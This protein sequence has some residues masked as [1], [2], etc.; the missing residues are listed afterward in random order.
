MLDPK[1]LIH[2]MIILGVPCAIANRSNAQSPPATEDRRAI[3]GMMRNRRPAFLVRAEVNHATRNYR[4]GDAFSVRVAS[5][6]DSFVYVLYQQADGKVFQ[7]F[8][9]AHQPNNRLKARQPVDIPAQD[10]L[11]RWT[12]GPP[13]GKEIVKVIAARK[14]LQGLSNPAL[15]QKLFNAVSAKELKDVDLE[16][17]QEEPDEWT[18]HC[19]DVHT[20]AAAQAPI[21]AGS[22]R[23]GVFFGVSEYTF[24]AE[25]ERASGGKATMNLSSPHRDAR[26]L[27]ELLRETG[28]LAESRVYT[29]DRA[30][31]KQVEDAVTSWLPSVSRPG[32]TVFIYFSGHGMQI[33]PLN[34]AS[35]ALMDST[36]ATCETVTSDILMQ[37]VTKVKQGER[38]DERVLAW[39]DLFQKAGDK[40]AATLLRET[41]V[42]DDV[43]GHWLQHL[44]GRQI[45]V[46]LD[47]CHAGGFAEEG[48]R[49]ESAGKGLEFRFLN[50]SLDRLKSI[51][52]K[53]C[54]L[55][56]AC[57]AQQF[58]QVRQDGDLSVMTYYLYDELRQSN[59]PVEL[60]QC[61]QYC[62]AKMKS[63]FDQTNQELRARG[64]PP[65]TEHEPRLF[66]YCTKP[67][68]LKP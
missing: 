64:Q 47:I 10:D 41:T 35:G 14:P 54:A 11:F 53:E 61:H 22:R 42:P 44:D 57:G 26:K 45:V 12:I 31:R 62:K 13:F 51:G 66:N 38:V 18:E 67:V 25:Y 59:G 7:I 55:L 52:Q 27:A 16:T 23:F 58:S 20:Y 29:N 34:E 30:T 63:Y 68:F 50:R 19:V 46:I 39:V 32:D 24:N 28:Q 15:Q 33:P 1:L 43:F 21:R 9:N 48:K 60:N 4:E 2:L 5:E 6:I 17:G 56:A 65:V 49:E 3:D 36:L 8:P 40:A 37:L